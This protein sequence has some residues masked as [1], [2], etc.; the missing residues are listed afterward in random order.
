METTRKPALYF[1]IVN[2]V[3]GVAGFVG[4][5]VTG[6]A[7]GLINVNTG[8]LF[9]VLTMNWAHALVHLGFGVFGVLA[10]ASDE[11]TRTYFLTVAV[12]FGLLSVLGFLAQAGIAVR[13]DAEGTL[14]VLE[15]A[16]D[17]VVNVVHLVWAAIGAFFAARAGAIHRRPVL[18]SM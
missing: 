5:F 8:M 10:R 14:L 3:I 16:A 7:D 13:R 17:T 12:V 15:V 1:G 2:L 9:G 6:N 11:A 18:R 4:P